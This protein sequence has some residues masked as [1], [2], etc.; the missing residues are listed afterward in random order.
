MKGETKSIALFDDGSQVSNSIK[1]H[2][3]KGSGYF[4]TR[5]Y[6]RNELEHRMRKERFDLIICPAHSPVR[7]WSPARGGK[8]ICLFWSSVK[9]PKKSDRFHRHPSFL[10]EIEAN[11]TVLSYHTSGDETIQ[12]Q[13]IA[14][15][16]LLASIDHYHQ[17]FARFQADSEMLKSIV[18]DNVT[19]IMHL[20]QNKIQWVNQQAL[21]LLGM[22]EHEL[23]GKEFA[24][25][26]PDKGR[27]QDFVR[28]IS[29]NRNMDGWGTARCM[30]LGKNGE[31]VD[32]QVRMRRLNP[33][34][35]Q[36][37]Y[38]VFLENNEEKT[39]LENALGEY[40]DRIARNEEKYLDMMQKMNHVIIKT[41]LDG[42]ITF[43]NSR[44]EATFGFS[45]T[46]AKGS[47]I[48]DL[49]ADQGSRT[50]SDMSI[51]LYDSGAARDH[52]TLH[53]FENRRKNNTH[54][55]VAWNTLLYSNTQGSLAGILWIGQ[56]ISDMEE[57][58]ESGKS[59]EPWISQL[60]KGMDIKEEVFALVF[61][62]AI[63][64][65]RGGRE[66][67]KVGTSMVIGDS[68]KVM[69]SSR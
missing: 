54:I 25:L 43:W 44:A 52:S 37:G 68:D 21:R 24:S 64:L 11:D 35:P 38:L 41:D 7:E 66:L 2:F 16:R 40:Q 53:V 58:G 55:W 36:K 62:T 19:G 69:A 45:E 10:F 28:S 39:H 14:L 29:R 26:F 15:S 30:L 4:V 42:T 60:L 23:K 59:P 47:N 22:T 12:D 31:E 20:L 8:S 1:L 63:E 33:M 51:L 3:E 50:A 5:V 46:I 67:R 49:V 9:S 57:N 13:F 27:Y 32:C 6:S 18:E 56:N 48:I 61:H 65:G 34:N 17:D